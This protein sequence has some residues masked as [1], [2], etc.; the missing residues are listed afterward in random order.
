MVNVGIYAIPG[1]Y[2]Y[3]RCGFLSVIFSQATSPQANTFAHLGLV[4]RVP[5]SLGVCFVWGERRGDVVWFVAFERGITFNGQENDTPFV[6]AAYGSPNKPPEV[7]QKAAEITDGDGNL[8]RN[9]SFWGDGNLSLQE[10]FWAFYSGL[11]G[12][13][14]SVPPKLGKL[15][16]SAGAD[17]MVCLEKMGFIRVA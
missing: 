15:E 3:L 5:W 14:N 4:E 10:S 13:L 2:G 6:V 17:S 1:F 16:E 12:I 9:S 8:Q 11:K 7:F